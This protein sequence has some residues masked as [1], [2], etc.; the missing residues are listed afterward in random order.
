MGI[1]RAIVVS[2]D[3]PSGA[4]RLQVEIPSSGT[5]LWAPRIHPIAAFTAHAV[6]TG[7]VVWIA[8]EDDDPGRP[9]ILGLVDPPARRDAL[10]RDL[11]ALGDAWDQGH[12]A[13]T[14]DAAGGS[15]SNPYR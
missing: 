8:F 15:T 9:V 6:A 3:D 4:G 7:S 14:A 13:G 12:A 11:E 2:E 10:A 5:T 1:Q